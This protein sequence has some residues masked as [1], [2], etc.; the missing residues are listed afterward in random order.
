MDTNQRSVW[1]LSLIH[2][3][4]IKEDRQRAAAGGIPDQE[5]RREEKRIK[6]ENPEA[7]FV[8][9]TQDGKDI[10]PVVAAKCNTGCASDVLDVYKRQVIVRISAIPALSSALRIVV[11]SD[12]IKVRPLR[13]ER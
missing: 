5:T 11:P 9:G 7:V 6:E 2:I 10:A 1:R 12:V 4:E 3:S 13:E 8:G